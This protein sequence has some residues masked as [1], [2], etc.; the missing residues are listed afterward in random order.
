MVMR[1]TIP[2]LDWVNIPSNHGPAAHLNIREA[3]EPGERSN[4]VSTISP[5]EAQFP[6]VVAVVGAKPDAGG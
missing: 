6:V 5:L 2:R 4:P 3:R 1:V